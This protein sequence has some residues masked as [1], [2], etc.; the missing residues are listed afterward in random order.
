MDDFNKNNDLNQ[1]VV[2]YKKYDILENIDFRGSTQFIKI[3]INII[4]KGEV[5]N[6]DGY[7]A[8]IHEVLF[9][10]GRIYLHRFFILDNFYKPIYVSYPFYL[11]DK[12]IQYTCGISIIEKTF[13]VSA[14][15]KD[16]EAY[17]IKIPFNYLNNN[18]TEINI[19]Y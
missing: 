14:G 18:L 17:L 6:I 16:E 1:T 15:L 3:N 12:C 2:I 19:K 4:H 8:L 7:I 11:F 5:I 13:I 9:V 10:E